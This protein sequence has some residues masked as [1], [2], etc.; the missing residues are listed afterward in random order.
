M[1]LAQLQNLVKR[2]PQ[3]YKEEFAQQLRSYHAELKVSQG[4]V[5]TRHVSSHVMSCC[6][7]LSLRPHAAAT[8]HTHSRVTD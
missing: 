1:K 8:N 2:E 4:Q 6:C 5:N 7:G 3:A